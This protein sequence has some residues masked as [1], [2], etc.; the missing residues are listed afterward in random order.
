MKA[1]TRLRTVTMETDAI[2]RLFAYTGRGQCRREKSKD[3][4]NEK[5]RVERLS[6]FIEVSVG[7]N[8]KTGLVPTA[9]ELLRM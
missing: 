4:G 6:N 9:F 3:W 5:G 7:F 8:S 2:A 1:G